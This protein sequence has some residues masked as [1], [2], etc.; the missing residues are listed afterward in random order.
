MTQTEHE[1]YARHLSLPDIGPSGQERLKA[2]RVLI[3]GLGGL[4]S[5]AALYLAAAGVGTVGLVDADTVSR[6]NL[7][8]QVIH[9]ET[10]IGQRK[11][12]SADR[13]I[14]ALNS[15]VRVVKYAERFTAQNADRIA[16]GYSLIVDGADNF[17][18]RY[19]MSDVCLRLGIPY[20]YGAVSRFEGQTSIL[21]VPNAPC[22]R[23]LFPDPPP[24]TVQTA[25]QAGILGVVPGMIGTLQAAET[26]KHIV[27]FGA[28]LAGR[29]LIYDARSATLETV[30]VPRNPSCPACGVPHDA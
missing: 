25:E 6:S 14:R 23:C 24:Y 4:G 13:R 21:C 22:Y 16:A 8:R 30:A 11:V 2:A 3:I 5:P 18:T 28:S 12:D 9:D 20:V 7:Q 17:A 15:D 10:Q 19:V 1:R 27:G 29:L 26:I